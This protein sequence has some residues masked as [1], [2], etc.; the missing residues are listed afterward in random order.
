MKTIYKTLSAL[1]VLF[2]F[3]ACDSYLDSD[4]ADLQIPK[5]VDDYAPLLLGEAYP[6]TIG[7][8][9][10]FA[11]LMTDDVEMGPLYY[12]EAFLMDSNYGNINH[13]I[14]MSAGYGEFAHMWAQDYSQNLYDSYWKN[15]YHNILACNSII[16]ALPTMEGKEAQEDLYLKI[17]Y[18]AH[19]LRAF[20]YFCLINT[21]AKPYSQENLNEPGVIIRERPEL[22]IG[23]MPRATI[24]E[25]YDLI[26]ADLAKAEEYMEGANPKVTKYEFTKAAVLFLATRVALFK[27]DWDKVIEQGTKFLR[28]NKAILDLNDFDQSKYGVYTSSSA[29][30]G[31]FIN[32]INYD[33]VVWAFG[34]NDDYS[35]A[36][37]YISPSSVTLYAF[38]F[39][40]HTSWTSDNSLIKLYDEDDLRLK[41]YYIMPYRKTGSSLLPSY[42]HGQYHPNKCIWSFSS[43]NS[44]ICSQAWRTPEIFISMAEA[45]AQK[46]DMDNALSYLNRLREKKFV[47]G[48][49]N[50]IK[51]RSDFSSKDA[52]VKFI[53]DERRRELSYEEN[54]RFWDMRRQ[55][56]PAQTHYIY[57]SVNT[58][59]TYELPMG[60][61]NYVLPIPASELDYND[62]CTNNVRIVIGGK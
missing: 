15:R 41:A 13:E 28:M 46:G 3:S 31:F 9:L 22:G 62:G 49:V 7:T 55:G 2:V 38:E 44:H 19:A 50:A 1:I 59:M 56:M 16:E 33:E 53:W 37:G 14:D 51:S 40:F 42:E 60:S 58:F 52:L 54:M 18:Q 45:Y 8:D 61:P 17:A 11:E 34:R 23:P 48:S 39:G 57:S 21:Y 24:K 35:K 27:G 26:D 29:S 25:V 10:S 5:S 20:N 6:N 43:S 47:K 36:H 32:D 12:D 4:S 30:D